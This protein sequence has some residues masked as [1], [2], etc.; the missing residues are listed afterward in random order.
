MHEKKV[1]NFQ[2][3]LT[4]HNI[5]YHIS[6]CYSFLHLQLF[7]TALCNSRRLSVCLSVRLSILAGGCLGRKGREREQKG[8]EGMYF[9]AEIRDWSLPTMHTCTM[10]NAHCTLYK[11]GIFRIVQ[12]LQYSIVPTLLYIL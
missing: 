2:K 8:R 7:S 12:H 11:F 6:V 9:S 3:R 5:S 1:I 10:H 4:L